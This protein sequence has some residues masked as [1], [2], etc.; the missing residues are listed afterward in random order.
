MSKPAVTDY[1]IHDIL[2]NRWSPRAFA[3]TPVE[4]EKLLSLLEAVRWAASSFNEQPWRMVLATQNQP[5]A[6]ADLFA[7]LSEYNQSWAKDVP[8]LLLFC[9]KQTFSRN[10]KANKHAAHDVGAAGANLAA[11]ATALGLHVHPMAG[12]SAEAARTRF[13]IPAGFEPITLCAIGYL[14][15]PD[16]LPEKFQADEVAARRR[17]PLK[18]LVFSGD[19]DTA[20]PVLK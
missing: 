10:G 19:W 14:G 7:C 5:E 8:V 11:Q 9:A 4:Q 17:K 20:S 2:A 16:T 18:E 12:F 6:Y 13:H 1:P 15:N 3:S